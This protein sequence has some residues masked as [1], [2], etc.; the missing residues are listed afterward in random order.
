MGNIFSLAGYLDENYLTRILC[1]VLENDKKFGSHFVKNILG[2]KGF[3]EIK[4]I[5]PEK[6]FEDGRPD[7]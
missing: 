5:T 7:I 2:L 4:Q 3:G 6:Q 1:Y